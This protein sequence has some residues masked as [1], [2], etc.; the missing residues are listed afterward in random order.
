MKKI[1]LVAIG[2]LAFATGYSQTEGKFRIGLDLGYA[3]PI[4]DGAG[5]PSSSLELKY[6]IKENM[7]IGIRSN[8]MF[9]ARD[10]VNN[11][12]SVDA[13]VSLNA[14]YTATFDYYFNQS[15][16]SLVPFIGAGAGYYEMADIELDNSSL[17]LPDSKAKGKIGGFVRAGVEFSKFRVGA[18]YN[19]I[20]KTD[21]LDWDGAKIGSVS[22]SYLGIHVG[23]FLGGGKWGKK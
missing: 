1:I 13:K 15:G 6:N 22:N 4:K 16:K 2:L 8:G 21:D 18:E 5:G 10:V 9:I 7:N 12:V 11:G 17:N 20:P 19:I 23:F 14:S 3:M